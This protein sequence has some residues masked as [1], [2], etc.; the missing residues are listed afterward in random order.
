MT[1]VNEVMIVTD[2]LEKEI[3]MAKKVIFAIRMT[4]KAIMMFVARI[5]GNATVMFTIRMKFM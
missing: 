4:G 5:I 2:I 3:A 1:Y